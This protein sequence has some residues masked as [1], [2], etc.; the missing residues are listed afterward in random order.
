M[1]LQQA[2]ETGRC[3]GYAAICREVSERNYPPAIRIGRPLWIRLQD[4]LR[5]HGLRTHLREGKLMGTRLII[6]RCLC[7]DGLTHGWPVPNS[8]P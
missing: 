1:T 3:P 7:N 5:L 2:I 8:T 6:E 4:E